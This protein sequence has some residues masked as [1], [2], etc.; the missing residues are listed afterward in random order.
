MIY[1]YCPS[2]TSIFLALYLRDKEG[3]ITIL[4]NNNSVKKFCAHMEIK[5]QYLGYSNP[6][7][8]LKDLFAEYKE[9]RNY[10]ARKP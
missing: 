7:I 6:F 10:N 5:Y 1:I 3:E 4:T 8:F 2:Y 9:R